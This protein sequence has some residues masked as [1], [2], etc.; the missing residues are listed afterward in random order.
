MF[1]LSFRKYQTS[2]LQS[3]IYKKTVY[4]KDKVIFD[5]SPKKCLFIY[6]KCKSENVVRNGGE[7]QENTQVSKPNKVMVTNFFDDVVIKTKG[8]L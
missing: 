2:N 3:I 4:Q 8:F 5:V 7:D 6:L 1:F